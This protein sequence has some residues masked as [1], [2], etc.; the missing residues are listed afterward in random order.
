M[1]V[2]K[3]LL[4]TK[5]RHRLEVSQRTQLNSTHFQARTRTSAVGSEIHINAD[6][7]F[8]K[9]ILTGY[10]FKVLPTIEQGVAG[11]A[12]GGHLVAPAHDEKRHWWIKLLREIVV[13]VCELRRLVRQDQDLANEMCC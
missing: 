13:G 2:P 7:L 9:Q 3:R 5:N 11:V 4:L 10:C 12:L 6:T 8:K 1:I